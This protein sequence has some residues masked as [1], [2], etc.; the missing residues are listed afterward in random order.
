MSVKP[1]AEKIRREVMPFQLGATLF[2]MFAILALAV[3][4][5]G[6]YGVLG[7]FV[8]ERTPEIG[9]RRSLGASVWLVVLMIARQSLVPVILGWLSGLPLR[10]GSRYL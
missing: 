1:L 4:G 10:G 8:T 3:S 6:L 2:T 9:V 5:I 7:Y